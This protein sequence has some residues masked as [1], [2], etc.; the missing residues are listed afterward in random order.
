MAERA[1]RALPPE[2]FL[3]YAE[4]LAEKTP[5]SVVADLLRELLKRGVGLELDV[6]TA[7]LRL[8]GKIVL[9]SPP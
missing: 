8:K 4:R 1:L 6:G 9:R 3:R 2:A 5:P 7:F